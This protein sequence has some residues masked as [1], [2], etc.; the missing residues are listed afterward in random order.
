[1]P[2]LAEFVDPKY[3]GLGGMVDLPMKLWMLA[4]MP[5]ALKAAAD[6]KSTSSGGKGKELAAA[7]TQ[8]AKD[9][10]TLSLVF[11]ILTAMITEGG[12]T[13]SLAFAGKAIDALAGGMTPMLFFLIGLK[14][15]FKS[16]SPLYCMIL[17]FATH[18]IMLIAMGAVF[19]IGGIEMPIEKFMVFFTQ[20]APSVVGMGVISAAVNQGVTGFNTDFAFDIVGLAFPVSAILQCSAGLVGDAWVNHCLIIGSVLVLIS[21]VLR[22]AFAAKFQEA[23]VPD[24][25]AAGGNAMLQTE[26]RS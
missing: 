26:L 21:I 14:L 6:T 13:K 17:L 7:V 24:A 2:Y 16:A 22:L 1:M 8:M 25:E 10:I 20:G 5:F 19:L 15:E 3:V 11:G 12:G 4:F 23:P 9:P 18:G